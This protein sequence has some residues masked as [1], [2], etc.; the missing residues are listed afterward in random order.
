MCSADA[1]SAACLLLRQMTEMSLEPGLEKESKS[2][3]PP[4]A[5]V[6]DEELPPNPALEPS[7]AADAHSARASLL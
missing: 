1:H 7:P 2:N 4:K 6:K 3:A 5:L